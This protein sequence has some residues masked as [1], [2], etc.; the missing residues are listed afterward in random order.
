NIQIDTE[1]L[2]LIEVID[3]N[4]LGEWG[5]E[6]LHIQD[7][8]EFSVSLSVVAV[9]G[10]STS[11]TGTTSIFTLL[12]QIKPSVIINSAIA[13]V[14]IPDITYL[15]PALESIGVSSIRS[16]VLDAE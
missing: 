7:A 3:G 16:G 8:T 12:L 14:A 10:T 11:F 5:G 4:I 2:E 9:E 15:N 1:Y 6:A 13:A